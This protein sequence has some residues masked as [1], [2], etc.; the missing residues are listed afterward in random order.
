MRKWL[1]LVAVCLGAFMLLVDVTIVNVALPVMATDLSATLTDLQ[2]VMDGYALVLAALLLGAGALADR[3]GRRRVY[4]TGLI[5][6]AAS[7]AACGLAPNATTLVAARAV[8][9]LGAAAMFATTIALLGHAYQG[10]DRGIAFGVWGAVNG[11]AAAT[12]P[13]LGGLLTQHLNWRAIFWVNLPVCVAAVLLTTLTVK[14]S[15]STNPTPLD[16]PGMATFT[17]AAGSLTYAVTRAS[18][19]G[20]TSH[21]TLALL[22]L[23]AVALLAFVVVET[24]R[25]HP[26]LDL[27]LFRRPAFTGVMLAGML[28]SVAAF[29]AMPY[30][31]LWTQSVL[32]LGPVKA[33]LILLPMSATAFLAAFIS[34]RFLHNLAPRWP[35]GIGLLLIGAGA[36]W[37][38][39][40][41]PTSTASVVMPGLA[42]AGLGVGAIT[43]ALSSAALSAVPP[44]RAGMAGGA[45][46][47]FRQLGL[48]LGIAAFGTM[49]KTH[50]E[51]TLSTHA[52]PHPAQLAGALA[53]GQAHK[54]L[55]KAPTMNHV[56]HLSFATGLNRIYLIA[57]IT[58][59]AA[60][61]LCLLLIRPRRSRGDTPH[62]RGRNGV[63]EERSE[64]QRVSSRL[65]QRLVQ[66][67]SAAGDGG[68]RELRDGS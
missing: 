52:I 42:L 54:L 44:E 50:L 18:T 7:S 34:G 60:G 40:I 63:T 37:Q 62:V 56:I 26:M 11:I 29:A 12:G 5:V 46:N 57:G 32:G 2:W 36:L 31:S 67:K 64:R 30:V 33:A 49:F 15:K 20:W 19:D 4:L 25:R 43:P 68:P 38:G 47:T 41:H 35:I 8:Q 66:R 6:F 24:L 58:G 59:L 27:A 10:R 28:L 65:D 39:T 61:L 13:L 53:G 22:A 3:T 14:E 23:A 9:G 21:T 17:I 1:P 45:V 48:A 55:T 51:K 16:L